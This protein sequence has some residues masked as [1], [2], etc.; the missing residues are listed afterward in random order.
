MKGMLSLNEQS[1]HINTNIVNKKRIFSSQITKNTWQEKI[2]R[3]R[4]YLTHYH[5]YV[6]GTIWVKWFPLSQQAVN[7]SWLVDFWT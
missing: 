3:K 6:L 7:Q 1:M 4:I 5:E 2:R